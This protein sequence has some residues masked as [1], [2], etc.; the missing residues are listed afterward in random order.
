MIP[1]CSFEGALPVTMGFPGLHLRTRATAMIGR[2]TAYE[3]SR[4]TRPS[5][6]RADC[7]L[8]RRPRIYNL[9]P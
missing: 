1:R 2:W 4:S 6:L 5:M 9:I 8:K 7:L 3:Q